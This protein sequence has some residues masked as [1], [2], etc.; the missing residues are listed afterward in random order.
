MLPF[1]SGF[2][3]LYKPWAIV[4]EAQ[5][6]PDGGY[7]LRGY[8]SIPDRAL[9]NRLFLPSFPTPTRLPCAAT[10]ERCLPV[11]AWATVPCFAAI[12]APSLDCHQKHVYPI[13]HKHR[14]SKSASHKQEHKNLLFNQHPVL[15]TSSS[16]PAPPP[17]S[18]WLHHCRSAPKHCLHSA[19]TRIIHW[20]KPH[21][22]YQ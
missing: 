4:S 10:E 5:P 1:G 15:T 20:S 16:S 11:D 9:S 14:Q 22:I 6:R 3:R 8:S 7:T 21:Q 12:F 2:I 17:I 19:D 13:I 18:H